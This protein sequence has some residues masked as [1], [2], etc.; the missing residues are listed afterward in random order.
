[1]NNRSFPD[2]DSELLSLP[3]LLRARD[4]E[5]ARS[6]ESVALRTDSVSFFFPKLADTQG[7]R[8]LARDYELEL[9]FF[10]CVLLDI[11]LTE[12]ADNRQ[13]FISAGAD[14][15]ADYLGHRGWDSGRVDGVW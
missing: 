7:D 1:M 9:L 3:D 8:R 12:L 5:R 15:A 13:R 11:G 4:V 2:D 14:L 10:A 6:K